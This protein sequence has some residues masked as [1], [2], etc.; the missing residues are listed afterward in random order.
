MGWNLDSSLG[1]EWETG[2]QGTTNFCSKC[3]LNAMN[4]IIL[5]AMSFYTIHMEI[6]KWHT[7][8]QTLRR[9]IFTIKDN[10]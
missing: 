9:N 7:F 1:C 10:I 3:L 8:Y 6:Y 2:T 5:R 4:L